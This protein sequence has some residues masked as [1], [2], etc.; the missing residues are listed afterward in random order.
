MGRGEARWGTV[1]HG[2]A[3]WG[4]VGCGGARWGTVGHGGA[5]WGAVGAA[6]YRAECVDVPLYGDVSWG[7]SLHNF[8]FLNT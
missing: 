4:M 5:W 3:R 1:G 7:H 8:F 2:G 6:V